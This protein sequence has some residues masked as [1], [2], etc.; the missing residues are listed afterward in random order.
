MTIWTPDQKGRGTHDVIDISG[1]LT[2]WLR[3]YGAKAVALRPDRFVATADTSGLAVP[4]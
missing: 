4:A 2:Q 1:T 3:G